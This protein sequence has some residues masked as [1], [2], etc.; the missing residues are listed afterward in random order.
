MLSFVIFI[1]SNFYTNNICLLKKY[2]LWFIGWVFLVCGILTADLFNNL[3]NSITVIK[4]GIMMTMS[5]LL[6]LHY[7]ISLELFEQALYISLLFNILLL[8]IFFLLPMKSLLVI[9]CDGRVGWFANWPGKLWYVSALIYPCLLYRV[10]TDTKLKYWFYFGCSILIIVLDGSRTGLLW[11]F[12]S[13]ILL[14]IYVYMLRGWEI[15]LKLLLA[16]IIASFIFIFTTQEFIPWIINNHLSDVVVTDSIACQNIFTDIKAVSP[17][18]IHGD[19]NTRL[20][21]IKNALN[22]V[23]DYFPIGSGFGSTKSMDIDGTMV[24]VHMAYLQVIADLG[25]IGISGLLIIIYYPLYKAVQYLR[26]AREFGL[27]INKLILPIS[28]ILLQAMIFLFHPI[29][30]ELTEWGIPII[31]MVIIFQQTTRYD[32]KII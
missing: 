15:V 19:V 13:S 29:S 1:F 32:E 27:F 20:S 8:M 18:V 21:M 30:N 25:V 7:R 4:Y 12:C 10:I 23:I 3:N 22:T 6:F 14:F 11:L 17:R 2:Y 26:H 28:I 31:A 16:F 5:I 9:Y 24:V